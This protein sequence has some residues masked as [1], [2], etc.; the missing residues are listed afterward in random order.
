M[1]LSLLLFRVIVRFEL[2]AQVVVKKTDFLILTL[3]QG[4]EEGSERG[5]E[6]G[7]REERGREKGRGKGRENKKEGE[8]EGRKRGLRGKRDR[9]RE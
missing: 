4:Y 6:R 8:E 9:E 5:G 3:V 1:H 7:G 2:I